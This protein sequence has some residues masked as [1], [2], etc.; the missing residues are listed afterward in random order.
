MNLRKITFS[1]LV[2]TP[3]T[4]GWTQSKPEDKASFRPNILWIVIEDMSEHWSCY[5]ETTIQTPNIDKLAEEGELFVNAFVTAPVCSPCR[6]ALI[7]GMYQTTSGA[8]NHRSQIEKGKGGGNKAY[9]NSYQLPEELP[10]LP[11]LFKEAG[12]YTVLGNHESILD[13][14]YRDGQLAKTDYNFEWDRS[15]YDS[16]NWDH[17]QPGQPFFAQIQ[18]NGGKYRNAQVPNPVNPY[19]VKLPP[20]YPDDEV[21]RKDWAEY[22]NSVLYLDGEVKKI[23]DKLEAEG[24][25]ENT[26]VFLFTD[27]GISHLRGKQYLYDEGI[28]IPMIVR[29]PEVARPGNL[30]NDMVTQIDISATSLY[31][32]GIPIPGTMQGQSFYGKNYQPA[33]Y[34]FAARDRCDETVDLIRTLRDHRFK[35][36]SNFFPHKPHAQPNTYKD[37]KEIIQYMRQ[38]Y[39]KDELNKETNRYFEPTR[40]TEELYDLENDPWEMN[41]LAGE[42]AYKDTLLKMREMMVSLILETKDLGFIPEPVLEDMGKQYGNKYY[43]LKHE[44]NLNLIK[45]CMNVMEMDD[46]KNLQDLKKALNHESAAIRFWAAYGLGNI[47][48]W[49]NEAVP[50]LQ[51]ALNDESD[52]VRI[53]AARAL[54]RLGQTEPALEILAANLENPNLIVGLYAALFIEDL[55]KDSILKILPAIEKATE[56]PY[57]FTK[58]TAVRISSKFNGKYN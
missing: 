44:E 2:M 31:L 11:K 5:G 4:S 7:T 1:L 6:S 23:Y 52:G 48:E 54:C 13:N 20:Y 53:A 49:A 41:N 36:I 46:E 42:P 17:R 22:L 33:E 12:Y 35:Y 19:I 30:R 21:L 55:D 57:E 45:E 18:L 34:V 24:I 25:A 32:A 15:M 14:L 27:H 29:L 9:Y 38:L 40:P 37:E 3:I 8:H 28:K 39:A 50:S 47:P 43:I 56:S 26:A 16:N 10:F 58:R 51:S